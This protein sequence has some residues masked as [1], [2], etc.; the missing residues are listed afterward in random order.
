M[1]PI[2]SDILEHMFKKAEEIMIR[3]DWNHDER[4]NFMSDPVVKLLYGACAEEIGNV[5]EEIF[6]VSNRLIKRMIEQFLPEEYYIPSPAHGIVYGRPFDGLSSAAVSAGKQLIISRLDSQR[7]EFMFT[8]AGNFNVHKAEIEYLVFHNRFYQM[9]DRKKTLLF[10]GESSQAIQANVL[11]IGI[12]DLKDL[13]PMKELSLFFALPQPGNDQYSLLNALKFSKCTDGVN[14][15]KTRSGFITDETETQDKMLDHPDYIVYQLFQNVKNWYRRHFITLQ[16][17][18]SSSELPE[19]FPEEIRKVFSRN[20]IL[21]I[22]GDITWFRISFS[23]LLEESWINQLICS[24]NCFPVVNLRVEQELFDVEN[25]PI[26]IFPI[27]SDDFFLAI[28]S[29]RGKVRNLPEEKDYRIVDA[30]VH[31]TV[32]KEGEALFRLDHLS[33]LEPGK[34]KAMLSLLSNLLKEETILLTKDGTKEDLEKLYR[35]NR[36]LG[37][38]EK[39]IVIEK[40]KNS[41]F[42]GN[43][44]LRPYREH[45]KVFIRFWTTS[46]EL[47]NEIRPVMGQESAKQCKIDHLPDVKPDS[48]RLITTITGGKK[49]PTEEEH[50]DSLRKLL[51]TRGR[52]L[53]VADVKAFCH[54]HFS[55]HKINVDVK[56]SYIQ[57]PKKGQGI[58]KVTDVEIRFLERVSFSSNEL[59]FLKEELLE[60]LEQCSAN[61]IPFRVEITV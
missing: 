2:T 61:V 31:E 49:P 45:S 38:F 7:R 14:P 3:E 15:I 42:S 26:N 8:P 59:L 58:L 12:R 40:N 47:A 23:N 21:K 27:S 60:K 55:P 53:T 43:I 48:L 22:K 1:K 52:I 39:S 17:I 10:S 54:E 46:G 37:E 28:E 35:L 13:M 11:W 51:L 32:G 36:A 41:R 57:S 5:H 56:K 29:V 6:H 50:R 44:I 16:D 4:E 33:R 34:L 18:P 24:I 30:N 9:E 19:E 25:M 20:D